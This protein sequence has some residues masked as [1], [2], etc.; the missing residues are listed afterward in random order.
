MAIL[1]LAQAGGAGTQA[2]NAS[3]ETA[4]QGLP[5][6]ATLSDEGAGSTYLHELL[7]DSPS[8]G[9]SVSVANESSRIATYTHTGGSGSYRIR[10]TV[11]D[12]AGVQTV[13]VRVVRVTR[14]AAGATLE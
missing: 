1:V 4:W 5:V 12:P 6:T 3:L 13:F 2:D 11:T 7:G 9:L 8:D 14:D 10:A